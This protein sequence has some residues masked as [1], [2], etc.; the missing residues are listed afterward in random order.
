[1]GPPTASSL[2]AP[3]RPEKSFPLEESFAKTQSPPHR[4][5]KSMRK[6]LQKPLPPRRGK[7][8]FDPNKPPHQ[9]L[10]RGYS[11]GRTSPSANG[12]DYGR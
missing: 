6:T 12:R 11:E 8:G 7:L 5:R 4:E 10:Y 2:L 3:S 9:F 1:M